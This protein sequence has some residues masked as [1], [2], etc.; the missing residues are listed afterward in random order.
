MLRTLLSVQM[1]KDHPR[2]RGDHSGKQQDYGEALG[3]PPL[4]QG[5]LGLGCDQP[6]GDGITPAYAGTTPCRR[7]RGRSTRDHP[8]LRG[9]H[10]LYGT[11]KGWR[12]GS[13][14][15]TRGPHGRPYIP[16]PL[17]RITPAYAG[18]T[19]ILFPSGRDRKD[20]PR[21]RGDHAKYGKGPTAKSGSPPLT[22]GPRNLTCPNVDIERITP[23]Y[24]GTTVLV[25]SH[26]TRRQDHPRLR[27]DHSGKLPVSDTSWGSPPLTRGPPWG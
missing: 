5:P 8:R 6:V 19:D 10:A 20:H 24:A 21:L 13:P 23:A 25:L 4:A 17:M 18:T 14:P 15:L 7:T 27:G 9:D 22:R 16:R 3:S 12:L 2:L 1:T 26:M 11:H